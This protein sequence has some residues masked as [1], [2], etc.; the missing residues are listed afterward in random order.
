[1]T[2]ALIFANGDMLD[3]PMVHRAFDSAQSPYV[4]AADG[5]ARVAQGFGMPLDLVIGDFDSLTSAEQAQLQADGVPFL[6]YPPEKD[7]TDLEL[8]LRH[9]HEQGATWIRIIGGV[10]D[11]LD[12]TI[13]NVYL[14]GLPEL[15][16][17]DV[18]LVA[19][20]Q[21]TRLLRP[22]SHPLVGEVGDTVSL[23]P[24]GGMVHG[25]ST[26]GLQYALD[27]E[28]LAFGPARGVSNVLTAAQATIQIKVG[29]LLVI[30]TLGEA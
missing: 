18:R 26:D 28:T 7:Q 21:E 27:D 24:V 8:A 30:H 14:L 17:C 25:I 29:Q 13:A 3:G 11:R 22:G 20:Q 5:G 4:V 6:R 16:A 9:V 15:S 10:G 1:M 12:Q 19:G 2:H 23:I